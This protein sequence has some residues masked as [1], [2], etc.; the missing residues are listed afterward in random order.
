[1]MIWKKHDKIYKNHKL[2]WGFLLWFIPLTLS[3]QR[4][5]SGRITDAE[6]GNSLSAAH[7][8]ISNTTEGATTD[9][10]GYYRLKI[11][12][13][14]SYRLAVSHVA[15]EPV[16]VDIEP[17]KASKVLDVALQVRGMEDVEIAVKVKARKNDID[18][19]WRV[20]LGKNPSKKTIHVINPEA[21]YYFYNSETQKLTV[22]CRV[23]LQIVN[24]ET[25]Y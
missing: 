4:Y 5:I 9:A 17:G 7:V 21:V 11:H 8:F 10:E 6:I 23:P 12:S 25:G 1:M 18:L 15:Y 3:G 22:T 20:I 13:E 24:N 19:F 2:F 16:F 14:G